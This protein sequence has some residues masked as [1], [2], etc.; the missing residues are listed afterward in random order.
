MDHRARLFGLMAPVKVDAEVVVGTEA[1]D[2]QM[3]EL[4]AQLDAAG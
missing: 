2:A 3:A 4:Q 1:I